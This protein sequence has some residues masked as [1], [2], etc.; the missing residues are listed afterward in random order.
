M[1]PK[2]VRYAETHEWAL[3][4]GDVCTVGISKFAVEQLTDVVFV[5]LA[6][7]GKK[8]A[9][10]EPFGQIESVKSVNDLYAPV[11][12]E[13]IARNDAL[14]KDPTIVSGDP[15]GTGWMVKIKMTSKGDLDKLLTPDQYEKQIA[16][17]G[18]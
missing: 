9:A 3:V 18:H 12:G 2:N 13:I 14:E 6:K 5:E 1:V 11:A 16:S 17:Q 4:E 8:L 15:Y 10:K 7:L